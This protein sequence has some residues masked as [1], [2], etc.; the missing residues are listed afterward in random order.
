MLLCSSLK[1]SEPLLRIHLWKPSS[2]MHWPWEGT[3]CVLFP[4]PCSSSVQFPK[5]PLQSTHVAASTVRIS[6]AS[7]LS[8]HET[9]ACKA[10]LVPPLFFFF[11]STQKQQQRKK[12][13]SSVGR[14]GRGA[15]EQREKKMRE[16][17]LS[18]LLFDQSLVYSINGLV[19]LC[20]CQRSSSTLLSFKVLR[21]VTLPAFILSAA[22]ILFTLI[23]KWVVSLLCGKWSTSEAKRGRIFIEHFVMK[24]SEFW[25]KINETS[26][27][28]LYQFLVWAWTA[29]SYQ[30]DCTCCWIL[31]LLHVMLATSINTFSPKYKST[32][33]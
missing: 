13:S 26:K 10:P 9:Q 6:S 28:T 15:R 2:E 11:N 21:L 16:T 1:A 8:S 19:S 20:R 3:F 32:I 25:Q 30:S 24:E 14:W 18:P 33:L 23:P 22:P 5:M 29:F 17:L 4:A 31:N 27:L 12:S 7:W